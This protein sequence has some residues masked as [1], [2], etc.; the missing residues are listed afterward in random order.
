MRK[1]SGPEVTIQEVSSCNSCLYAERRRRGWRKVETLSLCVHHVLVQCLAGTS[2]RSQTG[3]ISCAQPSNDM[4]Y[5][6]A[7]QEFE[8]INYAFLEI[9]L[10]A[11]DSV[12]CQFQVA[13]L[14]SLY[15]AL[16]S[17]VTEILRRNGFSLE[18][19]GL[20]RK[21]YSRENKKR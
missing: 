17:N 3:G 10:Y 13:N 5:T 12:N 8:S 18:T 20:S 19:T 9:R 21:D 11:G 4:T 16:E 6:A 2:C 7:N 14:P 15:P 1:L